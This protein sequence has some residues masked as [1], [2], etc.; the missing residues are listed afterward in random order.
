MDT[1]FQQ[2][3]FTLIEI[4]IVIVVIGFLLGGLLSSVGVQ[5]QQIRRDETREQLD[6]IK[7]ALIGFAIQNRR[8]PCPDTDAMGTPFYGQENPVGGPA[9][10]LTPCDSAWGTLPFTDLGVGQQDSWGNPFHYRVSDGSSGGTNF[11]DQVLPS[12]TLASAGSVVVRN[13]VVI[14]PAI[15]ISNNIPAIV[16][17]FGQNGREVF[18]GVFPCIGFSAIEIQNCNVDAN[19][20]DSEYNEVAGSEFDDLVMWVPLTVLKA[21]MVDAGQL[22]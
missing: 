12:F 4:A 3:G 8:L 16:V 11:T 20:V 14:P 1:K 22:P 18:S 9:N 7:Q 5:R 13:G 6:L 2:K 10:E 21:K 15:T 19:F 17:S